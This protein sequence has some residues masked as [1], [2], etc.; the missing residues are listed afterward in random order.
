M[1]A[2]PPPSPRALPHS[3]AH[4]AH[5]HKRPLTPPPQAASG[6]NAG[7]AADAIAQGAAAGGNE[8]AAQAQVSVG[9]K[10]ASNQLCRCLLLPCHLAFHHNRP[11]YAAAPGFMYV[12]LA[13]GQH[14]RCLLSHHT[15]TVSQALTSALAQG[16]S[17]AQAVSRAAA[18]AYTQQ[19]QPVAEVGVL[20]VV[21]FNLMCVRTNATSHTSPLADANDEP[22]ARCRSHTQ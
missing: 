5:T 17:T 22:A 10:Q 18:E 20:G 8:S 11:M 1:P 14:P 19:P 16:G 3:H 15:H 21:H 12:R 2:P 7:A 4:A 6:G 13:Q 9:L